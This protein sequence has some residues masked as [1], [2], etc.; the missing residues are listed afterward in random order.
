MTLTRFNVDSNSLWIFSPYT[1]TSGS[2]L[3]F[4]QQLQPLV[5][6]NITITATEFIR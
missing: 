2:L 3:K 5:V 1:Y 6:I 4:C